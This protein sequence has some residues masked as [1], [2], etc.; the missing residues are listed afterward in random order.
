M[1]R[2]KK[3]LEWLLTKPSAAPVWARSQ[4]GDMVYAHQRLPNSCGKSLKPP[5]T[6]ALPL[7]HAEHTAE[8]SGDK[9]FWG[10]TDRAKLCVEHACQYLDEIHNID[11]WR[12]ALDLL[13]EH[14]ENNKL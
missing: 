9:T 1:Y 5:D 4:M 10:A 2:S 14:M 3:Y 12:L 11:G 6:F 8:H 7:Y 13:T